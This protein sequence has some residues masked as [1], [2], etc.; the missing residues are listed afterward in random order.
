MKHRMFILLL[1]VLLCGTAIACRL[2]RKPA[3]PAEPEN[4]V[5]IP[6]DGSLYIPQPGDVVRCD[7]GSHYTITDVS[8]YSAPEDDLSGYSSAQSGLPE[9]EAIH[10]KDTGGDHLFI[11]NVHE[12]C[13]MLRT[14]AD[15]LG[16]AYAVPDGTIPED[17]VPQVFYSWEE[18]SAA[19]LF[20]TSRFDS[21]R[22]EAWD[23]Y[24]NGVFQ[25][26]AYCVFLF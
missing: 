9:P 22:L 25:R 14:L 6:A 10:L 20:R 23:M 15:T 2:I 16:E 19:A 5:V 12:T 26:T 21:C 4:I 8:A 1:A 24:M 11:R 13:R 3:Q 7:D 17:V 18:V